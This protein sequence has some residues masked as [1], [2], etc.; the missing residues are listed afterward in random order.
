MMSRR[1]SPTHAPAN[2]RGL[3]D[4][5]IPKESVLD[6]VG[7]EV[8]DYKLFQKEDATC[9]SCYLISPDDQAGKR[10]HSESTFARV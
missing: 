10:G 1:S 7:F 6:E 8:G 9:T 3:G 4:T 5:R 2:G